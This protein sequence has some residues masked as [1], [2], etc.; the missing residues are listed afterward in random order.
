[1][2]LTKLGKLTLNR[3][4]RNYFAETEQ[5]MVSF[6]LQPWSADQQM[7]KDCSSN[8]DTLSAA[9]TSPMTLS[10]RAVFTLTLTLS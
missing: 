9:S 2:P 1:M 6:L 10:F 8:L 3:N 5:S 7:L 4:P